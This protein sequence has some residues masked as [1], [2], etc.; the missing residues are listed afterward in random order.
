MPPLSMFGRHWRISSDDFVC[1]AAT[2]LLVRISW[3]FIL[4][5]VLVFHIQVN[6]IMV[7]SNVSVS[8]FI[9]EGLM[10]PGKNG[11]NTCDSISQLGFESLSLAN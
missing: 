11:S 1:P 10:K 4:V 7:T 3:I 2:E 5:F 6:T 8:Y 9:Y